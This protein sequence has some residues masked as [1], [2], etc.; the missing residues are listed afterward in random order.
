MNEL[1]PTILTSAL[2]ASIAGIA[3]NAWLETRKSKQATKLDAL[4]VAIELEGF[5]LDCADKLQ[6]HGTAISSQG[7]AGAILGR[8]PDMPQ[9]NIAVGFLRPKKAKVANR[10]LIFPQEYAQA[11]QT[12]SFW[13]DVVGD[14]E[15]N[16]TE[17]TNQTAMIGLKAIK[18]AQ[19]IRAAF[20]LPN[21]ELVF[22]NYE[23]KSILD[24][25]VIENL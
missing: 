2:V 19:D 12:L 7:L 11:E 9:L 14:P 18:L 13:W 15:Y 4:K 16:T 10:L 25:Y 3:I 21:R 23:V 22:G 8:M 6:E 20:K 1:I 17:V 5:A 24:G